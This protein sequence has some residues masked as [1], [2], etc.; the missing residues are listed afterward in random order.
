MQN[1]KDP[2]PSSRATQTRQANA[3]SR[4]APSEQVRNGAP[5]RRSTLRN[6]IRH[7]QRRAIAEI[8]ELIT[9]QVDELDFDKYERALSRSLRKA[10]A[11]CAAKGGQAASTT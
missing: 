11:A 4:L 10:L 8:T 2:T 3:S 6:S 1:K 5:P 9:R 7:F